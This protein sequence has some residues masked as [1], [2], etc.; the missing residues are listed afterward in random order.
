MKKSAFI[1]YA[2]LSAVIWY[3]FIFWLNSVDL[4]D[5]N[6]STFNIFINII[7]YQIAY[8]ILFLLIYK[9]ILST[10]KL[11]VTRLM[12]F[13][14][15]REHSEDQEFA[16]IIELLVLITAVLLTVILAI[17]DEAHQI[18]IINKIASINDVLANLAGILIF[19]ALIF[20]APIVH[21]ADLIFGKSIAR[22]L[23]TK[24]HKT[25]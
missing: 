7:S 3:L 8:G 9:A 18:D 11:T 13:K 16:S 1:V 2:W 15:Q 4:T 6:S 10:L 12:Y 17:I 20:L 23:K 5:I 22:K 24:S 25:K 21:E 14:S 19:A